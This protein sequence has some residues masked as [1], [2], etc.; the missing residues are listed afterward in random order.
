MRTRSNVVRG[1]QV[2]E[3]FLQWLAPD[4]GQPRIQHNIPETGSRNLNVHVSARETVVQI[5]DSSRK[6]GTYSSAATVLYNLSKA[7]APPAASS[8]VHLL[9]FSA[10]SHSPRDTCL[11]VS[12]TRLDRKVLGLSL[13]ISIQKTKF[14][15]CP[16]VESTP[17]LVNIYNHNRGKSKPAGP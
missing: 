4:L 10:H 13:G 9:K 6:V 2:G 7:R 1:I 14:V 11:F 15:L 3:Q 17:V 12:E 16:V 8:S 5:L